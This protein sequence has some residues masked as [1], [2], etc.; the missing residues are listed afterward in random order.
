VTGHIPFNPADPLL[1]ASYTLTTRDG[2]AY[3]I[4]AP[5]GKLQS[6][7]D[8]NGNTVT[9]TDA[10]ITSSTG[11][12]PTFERDPQGRIASVTAPLGQKVKYQYDARGDLAAVTDRTGNTTKFIYRQAPAHYL[13]QVIDPLGRTGVRNEYDAQGRLNKIIDAA[14]NPIGL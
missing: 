3:D 8:P 10:G 7:T 1:E 6:V 9:F 12:R 2:I 4:D 11:V 5:T 13:D 14:G